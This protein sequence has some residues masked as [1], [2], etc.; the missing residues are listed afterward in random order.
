MTPTKLTAW[1]ILTMALAPC[2]RPVFAADDPA[3][4][5]LI[6]QARYWQAK[7]RDDLAADVWR[8]IL[9]ADPNHPLALVQLGAI[10]ARTGNTKDAEELYKRAAALAPPA[11]G[12][13]ELETALKVQRAAP[14]V[15]AEARKQAQAGKAEQAVKDYRGIL[16]DTKPAGQFGLEYYQTLGATGEGWDEARRGLE[17]LA[18]NNPGDNRYLMALAHHLTYRETTRREGIRQLAGLAQHEPGAQEAQK[19]WRQ[20]LVWLNARS[21]DRGLFQQYLSLFGN[22]QAVRERLRAL[23]RP[24]VVQR[25][26]VQELER[27]A[28][29]RLLEAGDVEKAEARFRAT[30]AKNPHDPDALGGLAT[31]LMRREQ[32]AEAS[33]LLDQVAQSGKANAKRWNAARNSAHYWTLIQEISE[34]RAADKAAEVERILAQAIKLDPKEPAGLAIWADV[35][36]EKRDFARAEPLYRQILKAN[37]RNPGAFLGLISVLSQTGR[38]REAL[39][40][41]AAESGSSDLKLI[42]LNQTKAN[43]LLKLAQADEKALDYATA[44][45]RLEDALLLDPLSP[46]V[47]LALARQYQRLG[48]PAGA[49]ALIDNL[50][51]TNPDLAPALYAR[52]LLYAEQQRPSEGLQVLERIPIS[53]RTP[54]MAFDQR[55]LWV[56]VQVQRAGQ[57]FKQG[58]TLQS[59]NA[60]NQAQTAAGADLGLQGVVAGGWSDLGQPLK[61]LQVMRNIASRNLSD[62]A[63]TRIQYAGILLNTHQDAELSAVLREL[64]KSTQLS[65]A[66]QDDA[67]KIIIAYT[68]RQ[69]DALR[70]AGR[71]AEAYDTVSPALAQSDDTRL[72]MALARIYNAGGEPTQALQLAETVIAREPDELEHRLFAAGVAM[73]A[74]QLDKASGHAAA[75]LEL[76]PDH[77]RALAQAGRVEKAKGNL[78]KALEYFQYAQALER[79]KGAFT[80]VPGNLALR[81]VD[82]TPTFAPGAGGS[83]GRAERPGLLPIPGA[84]RQRGSLLPV[85]ASGNG[86]NGG[87]AGAGSRPP[88][89]RS[90]A[91]DN[92]SYSSN[93]NSSY[94]NSNNNNNNNN[95]N[96]AGTGYQAPALLAAQRPPVRRVTP[97]SNAAPTYQPVQ[98]PAQ[99]AAPTPTSRPVPLARQLAPQSLPPIE[100]APLPS[101]APAPVSAVTPTTFAPAPT[102]AQTLAQAQPN[103]ERTLAEEIHDIELKFTTTIDV[104]AS[105]RNR[106]GEVGLNRL[107]E[108]EL[109]FEL[110]TSREFGGTI[111]LRL[112]PVLLSAGELILADPA[113]ATRFGSTALGP[114]L[115]TPYGN[116]PQ[117]ATGLGLNLGFA[118]DNL[119][120][121]IGITPLGFKVRNLVGGLSYAK[122][123]DD[124]TLKG[125]VNRRA[126]TDSLLSYSGARDPLSGDIWGGVVKSGVRLDAGFNPNGGAQNFGLYGGAGY[127][128]LT[129]RGVKSNSELEATLGGYWRAYQSTDTRITLGLNLSALGYRY[130][131]SHFTLGQGGYFSPQRYISLSLPVDAVGRWGKLSYQIGLD[132]GVRHT[133]TDRSDYFPDSPTLETAWRTRIATTAPLAGFAATYAGDNSSGFGLNL[134]AA[135]EYL[136]APKLAF[137]GRLGLDNSRNYTQQTGLLYLRYAFDPLPQ[138]VLYPP[139]LVRPLYLGEIL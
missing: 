122:T 26:N 138:P 27:Q 77:P 107:S 110:K 19:A 117:E 22:D 135:F 130:N 15:L 108:I 24:L 127:S 71:L 91:N 86:G 90:S 13:A 31:V 38:E 25:P 111:T 94:N 134:S 23:E 6:D 2:A 125:T 3:L 85:P 70:E 66:Q 83:G 119:S 29:F 128:S 55:R 7:K 10:E 137:G 63:G 61:A 96:D 52:A 62:D 87:N 139:R 46:W 51:E 30:L 95:S 99:L 37:P 36:T 35:L 28:G 101:Y 78:S 123:V 114:F 14:S 49:N 136:I 56:N 58:Q 126:V 34:A 124:L 50:L 9:R 73:G 68:L 84:S 104:G 60:M 72:L 42:G 102:Q 76:A 105:Y 106:S 116:A 17:Q 59:N 109:P 69:T 18:R 92:N 82:D 16:G 93:D 20:A 75:A 8:K 115:A 65:A 33:S 88:A 132:A 113:N 120:A 12:L 133:S 100:S 45:E 74:K 79:E 89:P 98:Y 129:G 39:A 4:H 57:L 80:S 67:N 118:T 112:T 41:I 32:F 103:R 1:L 48:D 44:A 64:A 131:L 21:G 53:Q 97:V 121:D 11:A 54:E 40:M 43:A 47:R 5:Q 81:L